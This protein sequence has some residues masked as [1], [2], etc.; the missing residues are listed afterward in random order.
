[1]KKKIIAI[2]IGILCVIV[3][4]IGLF[5]FAFKTKA[6]YV[7]DVDSDKFNKAYDLLANAYLED[8]EEADVYYTDFIKKNTEAGEG[9]H[10]ATLTNGVDSVK[11]YEENNNED[12]QLP[13]DVKTYSDKMIELEYQK[14][15]NYKVN[16]EKA[17]LYTLN[18]DYISVGDSLSDYTV[19]AKVN[20][21]HQYSETNTIAL[22]IHWTDVDQ[23]KYIGSDDQKEF[24]K[25]SY[26]D[27]MAPSQS[28]IQK[29]VNTNIYNNTYVSSTPLT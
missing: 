11:Y 27:E 21:K 16:V 25:D 22:P 19:S 24:P 14:S 13:E 12:N 23:D 2:V 4:A 5:Q 26:G 10:K 20:G 9:E 18:V 7:K 3:A 28:R 8:G 1:M 15:A 17:G 29:W 6:T